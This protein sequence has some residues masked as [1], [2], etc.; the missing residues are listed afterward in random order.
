M[1][2]VIISVSIVVSSWAIYETA[3][4]LVEGITNFD[5]Q[6]QQQFNATLLQYLWTFSII[7]V[8]VGAMAHFYMT[9]KLVQPIR[10]L[11]ASTEK[12]K[13]GNY[14]KEIVVTSDDEIA[15][16]TKQYNG[17]LRQLQADEQERKRFVSD[18]SHELRTPLSNLNG[19][20]HA[21]KSGLIEGD[22]ALFLALSEEANRL[23]RL[24]DELDVLKEWNEITTQSLMK[25]QLI[26]VSEQIHQCVAM[27]RWKVLKSAIDVQ[28]N[29]S[30]V[31]IKVHV[32]GLQQILNNLLDNAIRYY[33]GD[34]SILVTGE[35]EDIFYRISFSGPSSKIPH[36]DEANIFKRFYRVEASRN[37]KTG[38]SGLGLAIV[39]EIVERHN[40]KVGVYSEGTVTTF[41]VLLPLIKQ[42]S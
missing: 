41:W 29:A 33:E 12:L 22:K 10:T 8:V 30:P 34:G 31:K 27:F 38:G 3:C 1:N 17:L 32:E 11:I 35:Q 23:S 13:E 5:E 39:K 21:L 42:S 28:V 2:V 14:P 16:L 7:A 19:Y 20:L 25:K 36:K 15:E 37:R 6:R 26:D 24:V 4:F 9:K 40:G 18:I